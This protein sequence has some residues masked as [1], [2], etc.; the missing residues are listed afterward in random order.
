MIVH[1]TDLIDTIG[2][3]CASDRETT[4]Y[5]FM[6]LVQCPGKKSRY[7]LVKQQQRRRRLFTVVDT[8]HCAIIVCV[9]THSSLSEF[10]F[11]FFCESY[12][13][14]HSSLLR[15]NNIMRSFVCSKCDTKYV[16]VCAQVSKC[17][18]E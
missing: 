15:S 11:V 10:S 18:D 14:T 5:T 13:H 3:D 7:K 1:S 16:Q 12:F 17:R 4:G 6:I 2:L 9:R 8:P